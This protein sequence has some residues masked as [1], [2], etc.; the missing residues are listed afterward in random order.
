MKTKLLKRAVE[1]DKLF[2]ARR[3]LRAKIHSISRGRNLDPRQHR[4]TSLAYCDIFAENLLTEDDRYRIKIKTLTQSAKARLQ[5][6][7]RPA[8]ANRKAA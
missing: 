6:W 7:K 8:A 2:F 4:A 3:A 1:S 5:T